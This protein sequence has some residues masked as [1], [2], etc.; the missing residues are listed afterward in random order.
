MRCHRTEIANLIDL[1]LGDSDPAARRAMIAIIVVLSTMLVG[2]CASLGRT[3]HQK[4]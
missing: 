4:G 1:V 2:D 3:I